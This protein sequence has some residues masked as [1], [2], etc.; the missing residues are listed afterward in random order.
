MSKLQMTLEEV[1]DLI[2]G[3]EILGNPG[4]FCS[5]VAS[6]DHARPDQLSFVKDSRYFD[7]ARRSQAGALLVPERIKGTEAEQLVVEQPFMMFGM[8]LQHIAREKRRQPGG[9][10]ANATVSDSARLGHDV[11]IGAGAVVRE[12]AVIGDRAVI[13]PNVY[14][15]QRSLVGADCVLYPNVIIMEDVTL[16]ERVIIH[17]GT[18]IGA[19]GYGY[20][21]HEG[22]HIKIPQVGEIEVGDDVEIGALTTI[23][24]AAIDT[25]EIGRGTKIGDLVHIGHNCEVGE[26]VLILP[27]VAV[28]GSV[29]IGNRAV[30]AGRAGTSDNISIG[31]GAVLG[32]T[33]VAFKDV[34]AGAVMWGNPAREKNLQMRIEACLSSL[35]DMKRELTKLRKRFEKDDR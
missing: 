30:L 32:G 23:D 12:E 15:G 29:S 2:G 11:T 25:T 19:D 18:I 34:K 31:E 6:L 17:G 20:L 5:S 35:P 22:K 9:I 13:Y 21:Q 8:I 7:E 16:G 26:D 1:R 14:I 28:S 4:F 24:R 10:H 33:C 3:G 27:T